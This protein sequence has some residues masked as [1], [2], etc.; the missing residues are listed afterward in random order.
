MS[1]SKT[2]HPLKCIY[3]G[4]IAESGK[5]ARGGYEAANRKNIEALRKHGVEVVEI[6]NPFAGPGALGKL[7]YLKMLVTP[8]LMLRY[9]GRK[10][11]VAHFTPIYGSTIFATAWGPL[12]SRLLG[13]KTVIDIRAGSFM[14]IYRSSGGIYRWLIRQVLMSGNVITVEGKR[15]LDSIGA[16]IKN[17][18]PLKYFPNL[19]SCNSAKISKTDTGKYGIFYF[20]R[21]TANKG[22]NI[23]ADAAQQLGPDFH[24]VMAGPVANDINIKDLE[25]KGVEYAGMLT[26]TQLKNLMSRMHFFLFPSKHPGEG[27]SNSLIEA[28]AEGLIPIASDNGFNSDVVSDCGIILPKTASAADYAHAVRNIVEAGQASELSQK[29]VDYITKNHNLDI[30]IGKLVDIYNSLCKRQ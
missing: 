12:M 16:L 30:E 8:F 6:P 19:I 15:Y 5:P 23:I 14:E 29:C 21:I 13:I 4:P 24:V 1:T 7:V 2:N 18:R 9:I 11:V 3:Y 27:Q 26:A 25:A 17:R 20:G 10:N 22:V 28:M